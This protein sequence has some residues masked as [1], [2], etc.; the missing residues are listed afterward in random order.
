MNRIHICLAGT[1]LVLLSGC[2]ST[3]PKMGDE[4]AKTVATG[5]AGG[6]T[7]VNE[8]KQ[9]EKC[10]AS[11]GTLA[12]VEDQSQPWFG[13]L[14]RDYRLTST[15]PLIRLLVQQSN[16]FVIVERGRAFNQMQ[17]ERALRDSGEM[18]AGSR[19]GPGQIVAADY[20]MNPTITFNQKDAGGMGGALGGLSRGLGVLGAVAGSLRFSEAS[21]MLTL[22]DNR[23]GVQLA[24]AEGSSKNT[25]FGLWGG[26]FGSSA[27]GALGGYTNTPE[28]KVLAAAFA[29]AYNQMVKS[30]KNYR[31][32]TVKGG[33]GTGGTLGVQGGSTPASQKVDSAA[34]QPTS[35]AA[36]AAGTKTTTKPAA[37]TRPAPRTTTAKP[38]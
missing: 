29:D 6:A 32:Q 18:R 21:T 11:M 25:D 13:Q 12:V 15:V 33:L 17:Q 8:N 23:S 35:T 27:G 7:A 28:G 10:D 5:S 37:R 14:T 2:V 19:M 16:C 30:V 38:Q 36:P 20:S 3:G 24:A 31:A 4:G 22:I 9:L 26:L 34:V 1:A